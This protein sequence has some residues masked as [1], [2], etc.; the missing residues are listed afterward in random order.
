MEIKLN[1]DGV[2]YQVTAIV[3]EVVAEPMVEPEVSDQ[4]VQAPA[5]EP[6]IAPS[7]VNG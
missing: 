6:E 2:D 4:G 5:T 7:E 3:P 1:I